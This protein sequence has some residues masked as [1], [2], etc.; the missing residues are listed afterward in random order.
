M[1]VSELNRGQLVELKQNYLA[2]HILE[3]D[4]RTPY[5]GE[6]ADADSIVSDAEIFAAE[7]MTVFSPDDFI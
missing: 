5:Y 3:A 6:L 1:T 2:A 4:G 7:A